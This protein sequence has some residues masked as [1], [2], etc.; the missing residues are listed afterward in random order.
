MGINVD[1]ISMKRAAKKELNLNQ[2]SHNTDLN[3]SLVS[4]TP[5]L[6]EAFEI[7]RKVNNRSLHEIKINE[8]KEIV[9]SIFKNKK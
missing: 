4:C 8:I 6:K 2:S 9:N 5:C 7:R 3:K 1:P